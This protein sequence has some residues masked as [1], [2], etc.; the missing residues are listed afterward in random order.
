MNRTNRR[1]MQ[2][3]EV[4]P[5]GRSFEEYTLMFSLGEG[6]SAK[7]ILGVGD[8]PA[9]FNAEA[10]RNGWHVVSVDPI[11]RFSPGTIHDRFV[12]TVDQVIDQVY[13]TPDRW[14]WSYHRGPED[15]RSRREKVVRDFT[16]DLMESPGSGRYVAAALPSLP[17][18][19]GSFDIA[20]CSHFLFLYSSMFD[21]Q[22]HIDS[23]SEILRVAR[24]ARIFPILDLDQNE[25][26][27]LDGVVSRLRSDGYTVRRERVAYELQKGGNEQLVI[28]RAG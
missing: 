4:V 1:V 15:L 21:L 22:F 24:Q 18:A 5:W 20:L 27:H 6:D 11:Y 25:S 17:F 28:E 23:I 19:A 7:R 8:G 26:N 13:S 14:V 16:A 12:A 3:S 2:L 9:S 10:T